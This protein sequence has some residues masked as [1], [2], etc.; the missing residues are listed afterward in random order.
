MSIALTAPDKY[1]EPDILTWK[2]WVRDVK[3]FLVASGITDDNRKKATLLHFAGRQINDIF[4]S[5]AKDDDS[6]NFDE[7]VTK[8]T[9]HLE[10]KKNIVFNRYTFR[11][12]KQNPDETMKAYIIR[13][14]EAA[15][16]CEF[17]KYSPDEAIVE[18]AVFN[19]NSAALRKKLLEAGAGKQLK[20]DDILNTASV[21]EE[22]SKQMSILKP[23]SYGTTENEDEEYFVEDV[24]FINSNTGYGAKSKSKN[25]PGGAGRGKY[26]RQT[27]TNITPPH[28]SSSS[29]SFSSRSS[30]NTDENC[31][32]CGYT[33]HRHMSSCPPKAKRVLTARK[34]IIS[35]PCAEHDSEVILLFPTLDRI[36]RFTH[37]RLT[38]HILNKTTQVRQVTPHHHN[39]NTYLIAHPLPL[40]AI[41]SISQF[42]SA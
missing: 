29:K 33:P 3:N 40:H 18:Q 5:L 23:P 37:N 1:S 28:I 11:S 35:G 14:K 2:K 26:N 6:D 17:D 27:K 21:E 32:N 31:P 15:Q 9:A 25:P 41:H 30:S 12:T 42:I 24:N 22:T 36:T 34:K 13:L 16:K 20:L 39:M 4:D 19:C 10:P 7:T 8:I 38:R